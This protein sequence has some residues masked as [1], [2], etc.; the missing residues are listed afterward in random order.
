MRKGSSMRS[1]WWRWLAIG[2]SV[3]TIGSFGG[4][5]IRADDES[6]GLHDLVIRLAEPA[7]AHGELLVTTS[8]Y[9]IG[10]KCAPVGEALHAQLPDLTK[11][12]GLLGEQ[13]LP[14]APAAKA[15]IK[16]YD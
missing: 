6:K 12:Q 15:G 9:R 5:V 7:E 10:V 11:D 4:R 8:H 16:D 2:L 1:D 14:D 3:L 13:V